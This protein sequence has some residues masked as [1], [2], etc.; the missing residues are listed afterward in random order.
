MAAAAKAWADI[1]SRAPEGTPWAEMVARRLSQIQGKQGPGA[2]TADAP[3]DA[4][5]AEMASKPEPG[6][7]DGGDATRGPTAEDVAAAERLSD[8]DRAEM[9][10]Q[11]VEGLASRLRAEGGQVA[12][13]VRLVR[14]YVVIGK[15]SDAR[16]ALGEARES[17]K[18]DTE[19]L[20]TLDAAAKALGLNS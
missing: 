9:I 20:G 12:D 18:G 5:K 17:F 13:W 16:K 4:D 6:A 14:S 7:D 19:A 10:N 15:E 1:K 11:M 3:G 8:G 2:K